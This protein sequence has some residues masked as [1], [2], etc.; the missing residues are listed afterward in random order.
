MTMELQLPPVMAIKVLYKMPKKPSVRADYVTESVADLLKQLKLEGVSKDHCEYMYFH[1][2][3]DKSKGEVVELLAINNVEN[4]HA[5]VVDI[6]PR[7]EQKALVV[8]PTEPP[9]KEDEP[10]VITQYLFEA[11]M[12]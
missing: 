9:T 3:P 6:R 12:L 1:Y 2:C 8:Q 5:N 7:I 10:V 4:Q 11:R